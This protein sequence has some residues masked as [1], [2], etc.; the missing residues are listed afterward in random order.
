MWT[1]LPATGT[2]C[3]HVKSWWKCCQLHST[4]KV[5]ISQN[6][7]D[8]FLIVQCVGTYF[9][10][11]RHSETSQVIH[12]ALLGMQ[13]RML[14]ALDECTVNV[15]ISAPLKRTNTTKPISCPTENHQLFSYCQFLH[16]VRYIFCAKCKLR[17]VCG[18]S[19]ANC[20]PE[21]CVTIPKIVCTILSLYP[22]KCT[23]Y[24]FMV[25]SWIVQVKYDQIFRLHQ[26]M[27]KVWIKAHSPHLKLE[28]GNRVA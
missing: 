6:V 8:S 28:K 25:N 27:T 14:S 20:G 1:S 15:S 19:F 13:P 17:P 9:P 11:S 12:Q 2:C 5:L 21:L 22:M 26:E 3:C 10:W 7:N 18:L 23:K 4:I 16:P 24:G